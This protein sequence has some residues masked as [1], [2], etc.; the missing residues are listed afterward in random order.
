MRE[1]VILGAGSWGTTLALHLDR[2]GTATTLWEVDRA[3]AAEVRET[4]LSLP[5]VPD[6]PLPP[7]IEVTADLESAVGTARILVIA[8]PSH[9]LRS[10]AERLRGFS[11]LEPVARGPAPW[12]S[13]ATSP[14]P[15]RLW[16][17]AT[18]GI[19]EGSG[20]TPRQVLGAAAGIAIER[21]V[22][23]AGPSFAVDVAAG[24]PTA[25]LAA[26][27]DAAC[28]AQAQQLFSCDSFRVYTSD[29]PLGVEIG[30]SLKNVIAIAAGLAEGLGLGR[31]A[32]GALVTRGLAEIARLGV[33]LGARAETFLGLA[34]IGDLVITC[35][36]PLSRNYRV[37]LGLAR[38]A[39]LEQILDELHMVAEGVRTCRS[40]CELA[41]QLRVEMPITEQI[42]AVLFEGKHPRDAVLELMRRPLRA[43]SGE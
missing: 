2:L 25:V 39:T 41:R 34:G 42:H 1:A 9:V 20:M 16:I 31:N 13:G 8:V 19:E 5:F 27:G 3:R 40:A 29:D 30:V 14:A 35:T 10:V 33:R 26:A 11:A 36:S 6:H 18:K 38:G 4:R 28:A 17:S 37:G 15:A 23:L 12:V 21:I 22:V 32:L 7:S 24:R 43:E